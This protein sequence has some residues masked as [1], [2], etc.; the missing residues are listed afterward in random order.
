MKAR[1]QQDKLNMRQFFFIAV[2][3]C[4]VVF[5]SCTVKSGIKNVLGYGHTTEK[6]NIPERPNKVF[7]GGFT[8]ACSH[9]AVPDYSVTG[10][11]QSGLSLHAAAVFV[12]CALLTFLFGEN[13]FGTLQVHP[14][15]STHR[16]AGATPI[17]IRHRKLII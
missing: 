1:Q 14:G 13:L 6:V 16:I 5:S 17:F 7:T 11:E 10:Q 2:A 9:Q 8:E 12:C 15:Y 3:L 4:C